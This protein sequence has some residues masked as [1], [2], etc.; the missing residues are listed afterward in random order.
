MKMPTNQMLRAAEEL[1]TL[2]YWTYDL[3]DGT[4]YWSPG[5]YRIHGYEPG[6]IEPS[7]EVAASVYND[8]DRKTFIA[9]VEKAI[10]QGI[11]YDFTMTIHRHDGVKCIIRAMGRPQ[12]DEKGDICGL[13]GLIQDVTAQKEMEEHYRRLSSVLQSTPEGVVITDPNG[14]ITWVNKGF[15]SLSGYNLDE[16]MG[17]KPGALL[18]GPG[19]DAATVAQIR[20]ALNNQE[21]ITTEILNYNRYG[22]P[23]WLKLC[24]SPRFDDSGQLIEFMALEIDISAQREAQLS[25]EQQRAELEIS[26]FKLSRQRRELQALSDERQRALDRLQQEMARREALEE[27]L[28]RQ[29]ST[30]ELTGLSNRREFFA[31]AANEITRCVRY[32]RQMSL[33]LLDIDHF[34]SVNDT[35]GHHSGDK[36]IVAIADLLRETLRINVDLPARVGGEEFAVILPETDLDDARVAA[37]RLRARISAAVV[38]VDGGEVDI[39][40]SVG[41]ATLRDTDKTPHDVMRR[42]DGALYRAKRGGR[43]RVESEQHDAE[44][45]KAAS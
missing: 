21:P 5:V 32:N 15:E 19:T 18:Q 10:T 27:E 24:I 45:Q 36:V 37:E 31:R 3:R 28:R 7:F 6:A 26:T 44:D 30:D 14:H 4:V 8:A 9:I 25:L 13:F 42:A 34:K 39:T 23:Y 11:P 29:A 33:V 41:V 2:G 16:C 20:E 35:Y 38:P 43:D 40:C 22:D 17:K 1:A 12:R